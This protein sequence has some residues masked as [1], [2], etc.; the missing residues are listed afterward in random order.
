MHTLPNLP[1]TVSREIFATLCASL[2]A[3]AADTPEDRAARDETAMAAVA[4]LH[5]ADAFEAK[6][7]AEIVTADAYV[8]DSLRLAGQYRD[9]LAATLRCRAQATSMMR[10]MRSGSAAKIATH[11]G[12]TRKSR[13]R[14]AP[15]GD[16]ARR[17]LVPR[18]LGPAACPA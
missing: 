7:A 18:C 13:S 10:Q 2:P 14:N 1:A 9:H 4:A 5:P 15:R 3:P 6:L 16:G 11:A 8:M 12:A 17:V